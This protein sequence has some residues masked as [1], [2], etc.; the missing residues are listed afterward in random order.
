MAD[1]QTSNIIGAMRPAWLLSLLG[2]VLVALGSVWLS[3]GLVGS[4][5]FPIRWVKVDGKLRHVSPP[6]V[7]AVISP[8]AENGFFALDLGQIR[9]T[10]EDLPWVA[11]VSVRKRWPDV[12]QLEIDEHMARASWAGGGFIDQHGAVFS[13]P[14]GFAVD[15]L[16]VLGGPKDRV[17]EV[18]AMFNTLVDLLGSVGLDVRRLDMTPRGAWRVTLNSGTKLALGR[19]APIARLERF[20]RAYRGLMARAQRRMLSADL[21]YPNGFAVHW[22]N[23]TTAHERRV[24]GN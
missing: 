16:P 6:Q 22:D 19:E 13:V 17:G 23:T 21:R 5:Q 1:A 12:L 24:A 18:V 15:S 4:D 14:S 2:L 9:R 10:V 11:N 3:T 7:R 20:V 8:L